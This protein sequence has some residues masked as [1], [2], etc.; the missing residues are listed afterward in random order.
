MILTM[1]IVFGGLAVSYLFLRFLLYVTQDAR[2]PPNIVDWLPF[3]SPLIGM[4]REKSKFF[5]K[6]RDS[7]KLP[8]Y[9]L[10]LPFFRIYVV[11][12]TDLITLLQ[13]QWRIISF[14][15]IVADAGGHVGMSMEAVK[16]MR[17][18]I[19]SEHGFSVSWPRFIMPAMAPGK[20][21]DAMNKAAI[22][23][24]TTETEKLRAKGRSIVGLGEQSRQAMVTATTEAVWGPQNPY[25][26]AEVINAWKTFESGFLTL[27]MFPFSTLLFP[28]LVRARE[29]VAAALIEYMRQGGYKTASGLIHKRFEHHHDQFGLAIDDIARTEL[30]NTFAVL[31]NSTPC[32]FWVHGELSALVRESC[33]ESGDMV[34][35]IDLANIRTHCPVLQST[36]HETLRYRAINYGLRLVIEDVLLDGRILLKKGSI[37]M[38]PATVQHTSIPAWGSDAGDFDYMRFALKPE[39]GGRG[40]NRNA[41]R[42]FGGGHVLCPGRHF[43]SFEITALAALMVLQFDV[44]PVETGVWA[45]PTCKNSPAQAGFPIPDKDI[46]VELRPRAPNKKWR[47]TYSG[48]HEEFGVVSEGIG[49]NRT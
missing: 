29:R 35:S 42:G 3:F 20:D 46:M 38:I 14:A 41:F 43:A 2:E 17:D 27:A 44:V 21:L 39:P 8:I 45:E 16:I 32:A 31:G 49:V 25:R 34:C 15:A 6:L 23:A 1:T 13:K 5:L 18:N 4:I 11:N 37:L 33:E 12:S 10:R 40:P 36:F 19:T 28:K 7:Y 26:D 48:G 22:K 9:T 24:F 47:V 30:G